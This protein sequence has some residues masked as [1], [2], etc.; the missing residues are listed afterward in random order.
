[1]STD[2]NKIL[3]CKIIAY[4]KAGLTQIEIAK[5]LGIHQSKVSRI[6]KRYKETGSI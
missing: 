4:N 6:L 3:S 5:K 1:M 2:S